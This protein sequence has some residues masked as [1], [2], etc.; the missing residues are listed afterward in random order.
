LPASVDNEQRVDLGGHVVP[1]PEP[2]SWHATA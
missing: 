1:L 2:T